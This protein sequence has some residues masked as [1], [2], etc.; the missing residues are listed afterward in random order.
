MAGNFHESFSRGDVKPPSERATGLVFTAIAVLVGYWGRHTP[1]VVW[2]AGAAALVF[3][4]LSAF[5]PSLL[6]PL[7]LL[8]FRF[9]LLL[10]KVMSP[11]VM[12]VIFVVAFIP[13]GLLMRLWHDPL[14]K[15]RA[16]TG[17]YWVE[18]TPR[19]DEAKGSM[20]NQF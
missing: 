13:F 1:L 5:A 15:H 7:N 19:A 11:L 16:G 14:R 17:T 4:A 2:L 10:H 6:K 12:F 8:W 9:S 18:R 20:V 3:L